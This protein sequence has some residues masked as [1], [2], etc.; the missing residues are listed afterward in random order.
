MDTIGRAM[1]WTQ[2]RCTALR[3]ALSPHLAGSGDASELAKEIG[4][5]PADIDLTGSMDNVAFCLIQE[6]RRHVMLD[7]LLSAAQV[8]YPDMV[9]QG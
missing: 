8:R 5:R 6:A 1:Y 3:Q 2:Q 4:L 9:W 7:A